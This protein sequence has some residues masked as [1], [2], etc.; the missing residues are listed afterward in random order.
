MGTRRPRRR[1]HGSEH[2]DDTPAEGTEYIVIDYSVT[3]VGDGVLA[4]RAGMLA[5]TIFVA[6]Q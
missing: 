4:V 6:V 2:A 1:G 3:Y 5:D